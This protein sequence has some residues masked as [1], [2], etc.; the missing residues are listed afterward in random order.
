VGG[1]STVT[2]LAAFLEQLRADNYMHFRC[3]MT[4]CVCS[5]LRHIKTFCF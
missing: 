3:L 2:Q 1:K 4:A 5:R